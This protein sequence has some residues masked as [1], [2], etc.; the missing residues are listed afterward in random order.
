MAAVIV[1]FSNVV[2]RLEALVENLKPVAVAGM[3]TDAGTGK[4][5]DVLVRV[6]TR[7]PT[8]ASAEIIATQEAVWAGISVAGMQLTG[9]SEYDVVKIIVTEADLDTPPADA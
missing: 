4:F 8:G 5:A 1:T 7:P 6:A 9:V 2:A 3:V